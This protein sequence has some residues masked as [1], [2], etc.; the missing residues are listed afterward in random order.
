MMGLAPPE[1]GENLSVCSGLHLGSGLSRQSSTPPSGHCC[2][3]RSS[4]SFVAEADGA[5]VGEGIGEDVAADDR[6]GVAFAGFLE[7]RP[8]GGGHGN[9]ELSSALRT[10]SHVGVA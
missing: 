10:G 5:E 8:L 2:C 7:S 4:G 1:L 6:Q 9:V 3:C